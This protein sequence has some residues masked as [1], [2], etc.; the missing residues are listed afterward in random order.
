MCRGVDGPA[1]IDEGKKAGDEPETVR[2]RGK[3]DRT[4]KGD[5]GTY[6]D[7]RVLVPE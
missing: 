1:D 7:P 5:Y 4:V 2:S 3:G 6:R